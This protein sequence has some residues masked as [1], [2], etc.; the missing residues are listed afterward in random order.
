MSF[1]YNR[2]IGRAGTLLIVSLPIFIFV[3]YVAAFFS[4]FLQNTTLFAVVFLPLSLAGQI[5]FLIAMNRFANYYE[6]PAIF[7]N[8]LY[9]FTTAIV[10]TLVLFPVTFGGIA[11]VR[12][13]I[14]A[15]PFAPGT[16]PSISIVVAFI[17]FFLVIW[18]AAFLMAVVEGF[19]YRRA[20]Y[21]LAER[22]GEHNFKQAGFFMFLGGIMM[23]I[24]VGALL[25]LIGWIFAM[26]GFFSLRPAG[27][28]PLGSDSR[29]HSPSHMQ[30]T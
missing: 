16:P 19:F 24:A 23:I 3:V 7:R 22:S 18:L 29:V 21:A 20:F 6:N 30:T 2:S 28:H 13:V 15:N 10:G 25:F 11:Y 8:S 14:E 1:E 12:H 27:F 5:L 9:A 26:L 17:V 4:G